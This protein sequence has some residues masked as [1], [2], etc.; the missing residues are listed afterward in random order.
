MISALFVRSDTIY[1]KLGLDC[2]DIERGALNCDNDNVAI[3]HP[4]CRSWGQ[5]KHWAN[6]R[7]GERK[8][9]LWTILRINRTGGI[10]EHPAGSEIW[11]HYGHLMNRGRIIRIEQVWFGHR[12]RKPTKLY[13]VGLAGSQVLPKYKIIATEPTHQCGDSRKKDPDGKW[14]PKSNLKRCGPAEREKTP[15]AFAKWLVKIC[16]IIEKSKAKNGKLP[17][18]AGQN[19]LFYN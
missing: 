1:Q 6:P 11:K 9:A 17:S 8:L 2:W 14:R 3:Y 10:F 5:L 12:A 15:E 4:P 18:G 16:K 13:I 19:N 7:A